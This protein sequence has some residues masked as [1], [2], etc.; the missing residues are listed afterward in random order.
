MA[1]IN[2]K[3]AGSAVERQALDISIAGVVTGIS[4]TANS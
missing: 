3:P 2:A 1:I 4:S